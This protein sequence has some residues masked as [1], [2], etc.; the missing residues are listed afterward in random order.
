MNKRASLASL[1][2]QADGKRGQEPF[3]ESVSGAEF[4]KA[5]RIAENE[6]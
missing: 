5:Q 1:E 2:V 4:A 6:D 3:S